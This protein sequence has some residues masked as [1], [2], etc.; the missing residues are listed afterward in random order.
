LRSSAF[1]VVSVSA[2]AAAESGT[3]EAP[4]PAGRP[5]E[6]PTSGG[7]PPPKAPNPKRQ[8]F[9]CASGHPRTR[10]KVL[11]DALC[12][13]AALTFTRCNLRRAV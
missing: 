9:S 4:K 11:V 10:Q 7:D 12:N 2:P 3:P 8:N 13:T 5:K 6:L 1:A